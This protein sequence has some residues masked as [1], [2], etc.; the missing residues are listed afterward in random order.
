MDSQSTPSAPN[1]TGQPSSQSDDSDDASGYSGDS[2]DDQQGSS[3]YISLTLP[4]SKNNQGRR[5]RSHQVVAEVTKGSL[6]VEVA[7][8]RSRGLLDSGAS[9]SFVSQ[10]MADKLLKSNDCRQTRKSRL[11]VSL[12]DGSTILSSCTI[13][14]SFRING[15]EC[16]QRFNMV[17]NLNHPFIF[18]VNF[19]RKHRAKLDY[20]SPEM[21]STISPCKEEWIPPNS[22]STFNA[23]VNCLAPLTDKVGITEHSPKGPAFL[24]KHAIV[25]P[26]TDRN[27]VPVTIAN[28]TDQPLRV[29]RG[30]ELGIFAP[31]DMTQAVPLGCLQPPRDTLQSMKEFSDFF[32]I[33]CGEDPLD[34]MPRKDDPLKYVVSDKL[35]QAQKDQLHKIIEENRHAFVLNESAIGLN[36][37]NEITLELKP[38][39]VPCNRPS[40]RMSPHKEV[41]QRELLQKQLD[42]GV[43]EVC[44]RPC[45]Y[46]SPAFLVP[47]P[48]ADRSAA[49]GWRIVVD[50]RWVN[51]NLKSFSYAFPRTDDLMNTIGRTGARYF[52]KLDVYSAYHQ[53]PLAPESRYLTTFS[54][55]GTRYRTRVLPMGLKTSGLAFQNV[56]E[57]LLSK[58]KY[59]NAVAYVDDVAIYSPTWER[60]LQDLDEVLK[61][62]IKGNIKLKSEKCEFGTRQMD[63]L[64]FRV[65]ETGLSPSPEK[66]WPIKTFPPPSCVPELRS[67]NGMAQFYK[68]FIKGFSHIMEPLYDLL[69]AGKT[70][71]WTERC[72]RA[73][74]KV[75][76]AICTEATL[77]FPR[78]DKPFIIFTD[79]SGLH[80]G[81]VITQ[82]DERGFYR[83]LEFAGR[84]LLDCEQRYNT[85]DRELLGVIFGIRR[86]H[87]YIDGTHFTLYS[88]HTAL[89]SLF[90]KKEHIT[91]GRLAGGWTQS[92]P[93]TL[94]SNSWRAA[95]MSW[96]T[97]SLGDPTHHR[98]T[99]LYPS[100]VR[101]RYTCPQRY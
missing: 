9:L 92:C 3:T 63:F 78:Y 5:G 99:T 90:N 33:N 89:V 28:P 100:G 66:I 87:H 86:F 58:C 54:A 18:G 16:K 96:L 71:E 62:F 13:L 93:M 82:V 84:S 34:S 14:L 40:Y 95:P 53:I 37:E 65:D 36:I 4:G 79:A 11:W 49:S 41:F 46:N 80:L 32:P 17:P 50:Y 42:Q 55:N 81:A 51:K 24:V 29:T 64:G 15:V 94:R 26:K 83:P 21:P 1:P 61:L 97:S 12:A 85:T 52:S 8:V 68:R 2:D 70:F 74:E 45:E 7:G 73:F 88:D 56:M 30:T 47:K 59:R 48:G 19:L 44:D 60:H 20:D 27:I 31:F 43:L 76:S 22:E 39:A 67:F 23:R 10:R 75:K 38:D 35:E 91:N 72:Q 6:W 25:S 98:T 69:K 101:A 77:K 57:K